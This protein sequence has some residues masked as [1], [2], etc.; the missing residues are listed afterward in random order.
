MYIRKKDTSGISSWAKVCNTGDIPTIPK[1]SSVGTYTGSGTAGSDNPCSLTFDEIPK[2]VVIMAPNASYI[3]FFLKGVNQYLVAS[4]NGFSTSGN[5][6]TW[7][8]KTLNWHTLS[9]GQYY[10]LNAGTQKYTY[11]V[12]Y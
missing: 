7:S 11:Y 12:A 10:Q 8:G 3:G 4:A 9:S 5:E 1:V 6:C 2:F